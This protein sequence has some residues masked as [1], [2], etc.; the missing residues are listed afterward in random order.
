MG[1][2]QKAIPWVVICAVCGAPVFGAAACDHA[3]ALCQVEP[4]HNPH[5]PEAPY[6]NRNA[7]DGYRDFDGNH[8]VSGGGWD[9]PAGGCAVDHA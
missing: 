9:Q 1:I 7:M 8:F 2:M 6:R 4:R 3:R 5:L